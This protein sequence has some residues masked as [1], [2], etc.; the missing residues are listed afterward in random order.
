MFY[1]EELIEILN[2]KLKN[3]SGFTM[4]ELILTMGLTSVVL[5]VGFSIYFS[6]HNMFNI[7][8]DQSFAQRNARIAADYITRNIRSAKEL[9][10][11]ED[12]ISSNNIEYYALMVDG[13]NLVKQVKKSGS[14]VSMTKICEIDSIIF[15]SGTDGMLHIFI[16][17][18]E[19]AQ[20]YELDFDV[21]LLNIKVTNMPAEG[22]SYLYYSIY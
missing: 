6:G 3:I 10:A 9:S 19:N 16:K 22:S 8:T 4:V 21:K 11:E 13:D 18:N 20:E 2:S 5:A 12:G 1:E 15:S 7:S 17:S 14:V